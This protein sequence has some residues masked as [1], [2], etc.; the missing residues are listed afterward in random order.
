[1][2]YSAYHSVLGPVVFLHGFTQANVR[3][4]MLRI[5]NVTADE[6]LISQGADEK[7]LCALYV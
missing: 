5:S 3:S 6:T 1:M 7:G 2:S 4:G